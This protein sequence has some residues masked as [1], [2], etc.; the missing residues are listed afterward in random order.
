MTNAIS[1]VKSPL[2][3]TT[4]DLHRKS[5]RTRTLNDFVE[6]V[7]LALFDDPD[8]QK[9][10][11]AVGNDDAVEGSVLADEFEAARMIRKH[12]PD[13]S[14]LKQKKLETIRKALAVVMRRYEISRKER[15]Q[16]LGGEIIPNG[17]DE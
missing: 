4:G 15:R 11:D 13:S 2:P 14:P 10:L 5:L 7:F 8:F 6:D 3:A 9:Y 17:N 12:A 1:V 16:L